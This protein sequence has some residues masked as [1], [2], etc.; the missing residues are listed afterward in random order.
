MMLVIFALSSP[1]ETKLLEIK[2]SQFDLG[3]KFMAKTTSET[4]GQTET[5]FSFCILV[6]SSFGVLAETHC[7]AKIL[8]S[9]QRRLFHPFSFD[10][11]D[12]DSAVTLLQLHHAL[13]FLMTASHPASA[14]AALPTVITEAGLE[15][16]L[17]RDALNYN[18]WGLDL[19]KSGGASGHCPSYHRC[20][21]IMVLTE[22]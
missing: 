5:S 1:I 4:S 21:S 2:S 13:Q 6:F 7:S 20:V 14:K 9:G 16:W 18:T 12:P 8:S 3:F 22:L 10:Q 11:G 19:W 17:P 15:Y